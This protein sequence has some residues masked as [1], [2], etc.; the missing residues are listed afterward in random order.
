LKAITYKITNTSIPG[1]P[2]NYHQDNSL[3]YAYETDS[4]FVH[5]FGKNDGWF[6]ISHGLT[7]TEKKVGTLNDWAT[8]TF[9]A[10]HI[11]EMKSEPGVVTQ[12]IWRPGLYF[13]QDTFKALEVS[14]VEM[15]L[16]AQALKLLIDRLDDLFIYIEPN[17]HSLNIFS[18]KSRELL[19][20]ACTEVENFWN[21]YLLAAGVKALNGR[22]FTTKD[23]VKLNDKLHLP[24][25]EFTL[26]AYADIPPISPFKAW[27]DK[28]PTKSLGWYD[29]YNKTKHDR[30]TFFSEATLG[31]CIH[32]V[33]ANL[34]LFST[35]FSPYSLFSQQDTFSSLANQHFDFELNGCQTSSFYLPLIDTNN[36]HDGIQIFDSHRRYKSFVTNAFNI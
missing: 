13:L 26:K 22:S 2:S 17:K 8:K 7:A 31:N 23:Y 36:L 25:Y 28:S 30:N 6:V 1:Y 33:V 5:L 32:A 15:R 12:L 16:A 9:G 35:M 20:L 3:G 29:A 4:H 10:E 34:V 19:I 11:T 24:E 14:S 21:H 18:H 27:S